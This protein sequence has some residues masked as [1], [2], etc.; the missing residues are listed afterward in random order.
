MIFLYV[1]ED[2]IKYIYIFRLTTG[3]TTEK[4]IVSTVSSRIYENRTTNRNQR[5]A[6]GQMHSISVPSN[7]ILGNH[8]ITASKF[9]DLSNNSEVSEDY[10][11]EISSG[12]INSS[13]SKN[14]NTKNI[15]K[16]EN[17][18]IIPYYEENSAVVGDRNITNNLIL[19]LNNVTTD[20]PTANYEY[21][22]KINEYNNISMTGSKE[23]NNSV[24]NHTQPL[25]EDEPIETR[26]SV[27]STIDILTIDILDDQ[28][29]LTTVSSRDNNTVLSRNEDFYS[30]QYF[31]EMKKDTSGIGAK[32]NYLSNE[33]TTTFLH[34][35]STVYSSKKAAIMP[36]EITIANGLT[37]DAS[38]KPNDKIS[39]NNV[40][41]EEEQLFNL[42]LRGIDL[43]T[44][45]IRKKTKRAY[46]FDYMEPV[47]VSG[48]DE[49]S[50][51][52][53]MEYVR[54]IPHSNSTS[55]DEGLA[56]NN[57]GGRNLIS[58]SNISKLDVIPSFRSINTDSGVDS[59]RHT[60][61]AHAS[62]SRRVL[63][64]FEKSVPIEDRQMKSGNGTAVAREYPQGATVETT[65]ISQSKGTDNEQRI[66]IVDQ[67]RSANVSEGKSHI[68]KSLH[69]INVERST[70][71]TQNSNEST[72]LPVWPKVMITP[73]MTSQSGSKENNRA[74]GIEYIKNLQ[75]LKLST[76]SSFTKD[77]NYPQSAIVREAEDSDN[78]N[79]LP[80]RNIEVSKKVQNKSKVHINRDIYLFR[81]DSR[82]EIHNILKHSKE[83]ANNGSSLSSDVLDGHIHFNKMYIFD[84]RKAFSLGVTFIAT[85]MVF[86]TF[87]AMLMFA[88][89]R[90]K[91]GM[92]QIFANRFYNGTNIV[93]ERLSR[94]N[95]LNNCESPYR[96]NI[97]RQIGNRLAFNGTT[98]RSNNSGNGHS[99]KRH[100]SLGGNFFTGSLMT[101][102]ISR[103]RKSEEIRTALLENVGLGEYEGG[104]I[105]LEANAI[106]PPVVIKNN[107]KFDNVP[108][109]CNDTCVDVAGTTYSRCRDCKTWISDP[110]PNVDIYPDSLKYQRDSF[111][112][113]ASEHNND[114]VSQLN[115]SNNFDESK[116]LSGNN[117]DDYSFSNY[118]TST[119][120]TYNSEELYDN[121][122]ILSEA[123]DSDCDIR[124]A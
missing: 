58:G 6:N 87:G 81:G 46:S 34:N 72:L 82:H 5:N 40:E 10:V 26:K 41:D 8:M 37:T 42:Q 54:K 69:P 123:N 29:K 66:Q 47:T 64:P 74:N 104:G 25:E 78:N 68:S 73:A 14:T 65:Y 94:S 19:K 67:L 31:T 1:C 4:E 106:D 101:S 30:D 61:S 124:Y 11:S 21:S 92:S 28:N 45:G 3:Q 84:H 90:L 96:E 71:G 51:E 55:S 9:K 27:I 49:D 17:I 18:E 110:T 53:M 107:S 89:I 122:P 80:Q 36:Q 57:I 22:T 12:N 114:D 38:S 24:L 109:K 88:I 76:P 63:P 93:G 50:E 35:L 48:K 16:F 100:R 102:K 70:I 44:S 23:G 105:H 77:Y 79:S 56:I 113:S 103:I 85:V 39:R 117:S 99:G 97:Q 59:T 7:T 33:S 60:S 15:S 120:H 91:F 75:L 52:I 95:S 115:S 98:V 13:S 20:T 86:V 118:P 2:L 43:I 116:F 83:N 32:P 121:V 119:T 111:Y 108:F 62:I 112:D